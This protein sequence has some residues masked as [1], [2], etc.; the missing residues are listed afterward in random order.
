[1]FKYKI[2]AMSFSRAKWVERVRDS[3][4]SG[5][6]GEY[7]KLLIARKINYKDYW[8]NE[9]T[10]LLKKVAVYYMNPKMV[11]TSGFDRKKALKEAIEEA[12]AD[13]GQITRAISEMVG[14]K[15]IT[16]MQENKILRTNLDSVDVMEQMLLEF[17][18]KSGLDKHL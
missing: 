9:V 15:G 3:Q 11:Q 16:K 12:S 6:L 10:R 13:Q 17:A 4:L 7:S 8:S 1:M 2:E 5:A 14:Y 18:E